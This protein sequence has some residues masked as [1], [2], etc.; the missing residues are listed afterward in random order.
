[1]ASTI[2]KCRTRARTS[3]SQYLSKS[4][5]DRRRTKM[6]SVSK[7]C[8]TDE[9]EESSSEEGEDE[10]SKSSTSN[11][12]D[13]QNPVNK[14]TDSSDEEQVIQNKCLRLNNVFTEND[15][16]SD[17]EICSKPLRKIKGNSQRIFVPKE[18]EEKEEEGS[19]EK[20]T[21]NINFCMKIE[22]VPYS[23]KELK[24]A[25]KRKRHLE[26]QRLSQKIKS[27]RRTNTSF[28]LIE[29]LDEEFEAPSLPQV[30]SNSGTES[31]NDSLDGF[32][33]F[34]ENDLQATTSSHNELSHS[35]LARHVPNF[36]IQDSYSHFQRV[37]KALLINSFDINFLKSLYE[38]K[39]KKKYAK[40]ILNSLNYLDKR[41]VQVRLTNLKTTSRWT[42]CYQE[43][44][45]C[46]PELKLQEHSK[47]ERAC[48]ACNMKRTCRF[49][50]FLSGHSYDPE[51]LKQD[52]FMP[53]DTQ[54]QS[55]GPVCAERT[56]IYHR[57]KHFK[58]ELYQECYSMM[59]S[60]V[61][62]DESLKDAIN[63][64]YTHLEEQS[65]IQEHSFGI[66][67]PNNDHHK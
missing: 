53:H 56:K 52:S 48:Q 65:W 42:N 1:M 28:E 61:I 58:Y 14:T 15:S 22:E 46:Y 67:V 40:E 36:H 59:Q 10:E 38:G 3:T 50:V 35:L 20:R 41:C 31:E 32:I 26:L 60:E 21:S 7:M 30:E 62:Q 23:E 5:M 4:R 55:V 45:H 44:V 57:I 33:V 6:D 16:S 29:D 54:V 25:R 13:D 12:E 9:E 27:R 47:I 2:S 49:S 24:I 64:I 37:V 11:N 17:S 19:V 8:D 66:R 39:R 18:E 51:S 63:R 43:R 34:D